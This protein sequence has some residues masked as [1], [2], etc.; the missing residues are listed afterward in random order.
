MLHGLCEPNGLAHPIFNLSVTSTFFIET[1]SF[2]RW[3]VVSSSYSS[4]NSEA[5]F[6]VFGHTASTC[7]RF[8]RRWI[9]LL[10]RSHRILVPD[11]TP[12]ATTFA[13]N[14]FTSS[15]FLLLLKH[16]F[17]YS[18]LA[19]SLTL[20]AFEAVHKRKG[21]NFGNLSP[22]PSKLFVDSVS[23]HRVKVTVVVNTSNSWLHG[24]QG[25]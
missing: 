5:L 8:Y 10:R 9:P 20:F 16:E 15:F 18:S 21:R 2:S 11:L 4:A 24:L 1:T 22:T 17:L 12:P 7:R 23:G 25:S 19:V 13:Q 6:C 3:K 14:P